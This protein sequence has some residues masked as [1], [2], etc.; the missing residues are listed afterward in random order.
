MRPIT[1]IPLS[2]SN[3]KIEGGAIGSKKEITIGPPT[4]TQEKKV[5]LQGS[6][7]SRLDDRRGKIN[8]L[9]DLKDLKKQLKNIGSIFN[10]WVINSR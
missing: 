8:K 9:Q 5:N 7:L 2:T 4:H 6:C 3:T 10:V 1:S